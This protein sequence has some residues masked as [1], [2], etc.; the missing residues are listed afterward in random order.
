[1]WVSMPGTA[2]IFCPN[3]GT[4]NEWS[5]ST[6]SIVNCACLP[7]GSTSSPDSSSPYSGYWNFHANCWPIAVTCKELSLALPFSESTNA[8]T[9]PSA[10][11]R[12]A[13]TAVQTI[14][15]PVLPWIGGPSAS[16][17]GCTRHF[18]TENTTTA[19]TSEKMTMD[20][21]VANQ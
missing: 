6:A 1:M 16:S 4:Q 21:T 9:M 17:S 14:S 8:L 10:I 15:R 13:G 20:I 3:C 18:H 5:T 7:T 2:S 19:A 11:T 12:M